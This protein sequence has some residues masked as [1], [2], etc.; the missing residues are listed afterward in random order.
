L[1]TTVVNPYKSYN[2][3]GDAKDNHLFRSVVFSD[4]IGARSTGYNNV[5]P[6]YGYGDWRK[7]PAPFYDNP[8]RRDDLS[9]AIPIDGV[10]YVRGDVFLEGWYKGLGTLV[11][12]GN[13]YVGG[14][15]MG[16]PPTLTGYHSLL[17]LIVLEDP[18]RESSTQGLYRKNTGKIIYKP[19]HDRDWD[20]LH[21][22]LLREMNPVLDIAVYA[23]NGMDVDRTSL[24]DD[25]FNMQ[26]EFNFATENFDQQKLP[27]D[28]TIFGT[29]PQVILKRE[30]MD[31]SEAFVY[32]VIGTEYLSWK[33]ETP[34][35]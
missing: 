23:K 12:E 25:F 22:N 27:N 33:I 4:A 13:V 32:P 3:D 5:L 1:A 7:V 2:K 16:L 30:G 17:N 31:A 11:V 18:G 29:D 19:H 20:K 10:T 26:I 8:T 24:F 35:L 6:L 28:L 21:L 14:D 9:Q 15:V 34:T